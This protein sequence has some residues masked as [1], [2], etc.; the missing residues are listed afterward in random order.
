MW[1][2]KANGKQVKTEHITNLHIHVAEAD[3]N[4]EN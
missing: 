3:A 4:L 2:V 1:T